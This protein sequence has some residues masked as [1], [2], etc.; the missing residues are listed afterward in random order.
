M[1][2]TSRLALRP[3]PGPSPAEGGGSRRPAR[4]GGLRL[5]IAICAALGGVALLHHPVQAAAHRAALVIEHGGGE[6]VSRCVTFAEDHL[7]GLQLIQRS[8][9]EYQVRNFGSLGN[10]VCQLDREPAT[11]PAGCFGSGATWQ[12]F[13]RTGTSWKQASA[14]PQTSTVADGGMDGWLYAAGTASPSAR[15]TFSQVCRPAA[16]V[17]PSRPASLPV[18]V[19]AGIAAGVALLVLGA[20]TALNLRRRHT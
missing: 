1:E 6:I 18:P 7:S 17:A 12:Y 19:A 16:A 11:V 10:A 2:S 4:W 15:V 3:P 14:G 13:Q 5:F 8:G 9:I 20:L